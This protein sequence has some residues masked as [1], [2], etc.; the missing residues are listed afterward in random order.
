MLVVAGS[1]LFLHLFDCVLFV[2]VCC[3]VCGLLIVDFVLV[4]VVSCLLLVSYF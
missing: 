3:G 2:V 1:T 4:A